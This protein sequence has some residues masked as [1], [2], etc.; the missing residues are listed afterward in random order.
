MNHLSTV[1]RRESQMRNGFWTSDQLDKEEEK[2]QS[3][4]ARMETIKKI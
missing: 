3:D 2:D 4:E 1:K